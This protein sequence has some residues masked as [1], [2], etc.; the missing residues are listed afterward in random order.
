MKL[1]FV[2]LLAVSFLL[3]PLPLN[4][5]ELFPGRYQAMVIGRGSNVFVIDTK[6]GHCWDYDLNAN[7]LRY[8][9]EFRAGVKFG[10]VISEADEKTLEELREE[11]EELQRK[12]ADR[13]REIKEEEVKREEESKGAPTELQRAIARAEL[14]EELK[15]E[16]IGAIE[17]EDLREEQKSELK[18]VIEN[19]D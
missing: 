8:L 2:L 14:K 6:E 13:E 17:A 15:E 11:M 12:I 7:K 18:R 19:L 10:E 5:A 16:I 4:A 3:M 9:G 1:G